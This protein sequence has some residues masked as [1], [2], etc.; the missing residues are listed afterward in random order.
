VTKKFLIWPL[1]TVLLTTA[2]PAH[3]QQPTKIPRIGFLSGR[4]NPTPTTPDPNAQAFRQGLR[5]LNYIEGKNILVEYRYLE[6]K[7]DRI[8]T[9]L[10][11]LLQLKVDVLVSPHGSSIRAAQ[12]ATKMIPI[13]I[14]I[15]QA[16][17]PL[18]LSIAW[19]AQVEI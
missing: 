7:G 4:G 10:A 14:V 1:T 16:Q 9:F 18:G 8:P 11:E 3:A 13:V 19:R 2:L 17:L 5:D 6:G 12:Q 15:N